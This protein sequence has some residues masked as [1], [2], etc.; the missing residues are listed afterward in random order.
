MKK[1]L[2]VL[3]LFTLF[4]VKGMEELDL[5]PKAKSAILIEAVSGEIIYQKCSY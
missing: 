2:I 1:I 3:L 5:T 4:P